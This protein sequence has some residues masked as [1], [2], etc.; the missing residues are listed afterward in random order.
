MT[1][2]S[3]RRSNFFARLSPR[4]VNV[5]APRIHMLMES[6]PSHVDLEEPVEAFRMK[7]GRM[8]VLRM[9]DNGVNEEKS[10]MFNRLLAEKGFKFPLRAINGNPMTKKEYDQGYILIDDSHQVFHLKQMRGLPYVKNVGL[11]TSLKMKNALIAEFPDRKNLAFL[12][13]GSDSLYVLTSAYELRRMP[14]RHDPGRESLL[15]IGDMLHWT[16]KVGGEDASSVYALDAGTYEMVDSLRYEYPAGGMEK[17]SEALFP[18]TLSFTSGGD[19]WV[20]PRLEGF[21]VAAVLL[22]SLLAAVYLAV[23]RREMKRSLPYAGV[24]LLAGIFAFI[25]FLTIRK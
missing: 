7:N 2:A 15:I 5:T 20:K 6:M 11:D 13:D 14:L 23:R 9:S 3:I 12:T 18:F 16:V 25:P 4:D 17:V 22:N 21:S 10:A 19:K 8:T 1:A 24:I